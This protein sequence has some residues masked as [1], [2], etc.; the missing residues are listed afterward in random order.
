MPN[1]KT[2][3]ISDNY[4]TS[5]K[6][7]AEWIPTASREDMFRSF[8]RYI[9]VIGISTFRMLINAGMKFDEKICK[10]SKNA[11]KHFGRIAYMYIICGKVEE[12]PVH[13]LVY[14]VIVAAITWPGLSEQERMLNY[15]DKSGWK[16]NDLVRYRILELGYSLD[17][18]NYYFEWGRRNCEMFYPRK[19]CNINAIKFF[20]KCGKRDRV[21]TKKN[22]EWNMLWGT[23]ESIEF[24]KKQLEGTC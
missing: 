11:L 21:I 19:L 4:S 9:S 2:V 22:L 7:F 17:N 14:K 3:F 10:Q 5:F 12:I 18:Y 16:D 15:I 20:C 8:C 24:I 13:M 23:D 6:K 1:I